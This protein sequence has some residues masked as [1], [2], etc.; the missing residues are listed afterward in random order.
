M[1]RV[2]GHEPHLITGAPERLD[3]DLVV[4][5]RRH[6]VAGLRL[7]LPPYH[8]LVAICDGSA[9]HRVAGHREHEQAATADQLPR[10]WIDAVDRFLSE[11]RTT[12]GDPSHQRH[13]NWLLRRDVDTWNLT[14]PGFPAAGLQPNGRVAW[15]SHL[16]CP[17]LSGV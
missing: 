9:D 6:D 10:Q 2:M 1:S 13:V 8:D 17:R 14:C 12:R 4:D 3:R 15:Q 11:D 16:Y 7:T 5:H